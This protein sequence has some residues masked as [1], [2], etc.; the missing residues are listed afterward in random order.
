M[1]FLYSFFDQVL[2]YSKEKNKRSTMKI[3][4]CNQKGD[5]K[6]Y[7][8]CKIRSHPL[9][10]RDQGKNLLIYKLVVEAKI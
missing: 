8:V 3:D 6:Y 4:I 9:T 2:S 10:G 7:R 1:R 5:R